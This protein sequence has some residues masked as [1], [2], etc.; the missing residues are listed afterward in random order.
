[1]ENEIITHAGFWDCE[2]E[3]NFQHDKEKSKYCELCGKMAEEQPDS[4]LSELIENGMIKARL[5]RDAWLESR[6]AGIGGSDI[7]AILGL[8]PW[9]NALSVWLD[10]KGLSSPKEETVQ[11]KMGHRLEPV[12]ADMYSE[13]TGNELAMA[14]LMVHPDFPFIIGTPDRLNVT[15][16]N[17]GLEIKT[18]NVFR[19]ISGWGD[20]GTDEIPENYLLQCVWYM[21]VA[22]R[23][24][25]DV[26]VL[27]GGAD[28]RIYKIHR[29]KDLENALIERAA[30]WWK[31]Y[32]IGNEEPPIDGSVAAAEYLTRRFSHNV[33]PLKIA[34][35]EVDDIL[36]KMLASRLAI[37][38]LEGQLATYE[39]QVKLFIGDA[40]GVE[41]TGFRA[42]WKNSKDSE[43]TDWEALA[44]KMINHLPAKD[45]EW[46]L[47]KYTTLNPG[48]RRFLF[49]KKGE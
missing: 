34:T 36:V 23:D 37:G 38:Q 16:P 15:H 42:T 3:D 19:G 25:W 6:R 49:T 4:L 29:D 5:A 48:S 32:I 22:N 33:E 31:K 11:M 27:I 39:N 28:F 41:S 13:A 21:A 47:D 2:C 24:I 46:V 8:S 45:R 30:D 1:M 7:A 12:I 14:G 26:A 10:K 18:A 35:Q 20:P 17:A 43:K 9:G 40:A 44:L